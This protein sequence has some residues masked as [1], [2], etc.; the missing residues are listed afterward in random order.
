MYPF[1]T[2]TNHIDCQN[3]ENQ[4]HDTQKAGKNAVSDGDKNSPSFENLEVE[5]QQQLTIDHPS[6]AKSHP[7]REDSA[8]DNN[9]HP[10]PAQQLKGGGDS[11]GKITHGIHRTAKF[12]TE[13]GV[14]QELVASQGRGDDE[15]GSSHGYF[16][17]NLWQGEVNE[18]SSH[19]KGQLEA[20]DKDIG[21]AVDRYQKL[22]DWWPEGGT[23]HHKKGSDNNPRT[24]LD[25]HALNHHQ[26]HHRTT[27]HHHHHH[28]SHSSHHHTHTHH[29]GISKT[30]EST[31]QL[32][33]ETH[34]LAHRPSS[35]RPRVPQG[36]KRPAI[37]QRPSPNTADYDV[38]FRVSGDASVK[39]S[40]N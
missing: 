6:K 11:R 30:G 38:W 18:G 22:L 32:N 28:H 10:P 25:Q 5:E 27:H 17:T 20:G 24:F 3:E 15:S 13:F 40:K 37:I 34:P 21:P 33:R 7:V 4:P 2:D 29:Q 31:E 36:Q 35:K 12:V 23:D 16:R 39:L 26:N 19:Q 1:V 8:G 9:S 14:W